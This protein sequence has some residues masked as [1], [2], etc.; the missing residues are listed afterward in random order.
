MLLGPIPAGATDPPAAFTTAA[1]L[2][3]IAGLLGVAGLGIT[4]GPVADLLHTAA[5]IVEAP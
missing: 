5:T 2:P 4:L 3:L 1:A